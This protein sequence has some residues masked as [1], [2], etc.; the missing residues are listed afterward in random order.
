MFRRCGLPLLSS[1]TPA[2]FSSASFTAG[3]GEENER[4][5]SMRTRHTGTAEDEGWSGSA[6]RGSGGSAAVRPTIETYRAMTNTELETLLKQREQQVRQLRVVYENFHYEV[7]KCFRTMVFDYHEKAL[8]LSQVHGKM[9][10]GSLQI[11]REALVKM[12]EQQE[13]YS[14]DHRIVLTICTVLSFAFWVWVRRHYVHREELY[15]VQPERQQDSSARE[16]TRSVSGAG[17]FNENLFTSAKRN[18]RNV[19]TS[20]EREVRESG[21]TRGHQSV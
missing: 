18:S 10:L 3:L 19:E 13:M 17:S 2:G 7:D 9:Q 4:L 8:Q 1:T 21:R 15:G 5:E 11:S 16:R 12:R 14:R 6:K 20:W